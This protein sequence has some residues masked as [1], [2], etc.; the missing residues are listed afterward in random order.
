[1]RACVCVCAHACVH[2][3]G[4]H[5]GTC[6]ICAVLHVLFELCLSAALIYNHLRS[7]SVCDAAQHYILWFV[8]TGGV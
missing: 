7:C 3:Y 2:A 6:V 8:L 5:V 4:M 1:M